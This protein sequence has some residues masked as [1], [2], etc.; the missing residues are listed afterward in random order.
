MENG[1]CHVVRVAGKET[2]FVKNWLRGALQGLQ[3]VVGVDVY[4]KAFV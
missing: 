4:R 2:E 3:A 1:K